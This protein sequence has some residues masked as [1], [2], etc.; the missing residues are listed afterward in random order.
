[1]TDAIGIE[2]VGTYVPRRRLSAEAVTEAWNRFDGA[3]IRQTSVPGPD[4]DSLTMAAEAARRALDE[5][6]VEPS[7][8]EALVFATTTP[9]LEESDLSVRLGE[10]LGVDEDATHTL[11][12]GSTNAGV[13]ALTTALADDDGPTLVV[14]SD[15]PRGKPDSALDHAA[16]AGAAAFVLVPDGPAAIVDRADY[17]SDYP[18]TRFREPGS[19]TVD[20]LDITPYDRSAYTETI[21]GAVENLDVDPSS[22]DVVVLQAPNGGLP[23]RGAKAIGVPSDVVESHAIVHDLGDLGAASVPLSLANALVDGADRVLAVGYGSG[24]TATALSVEQSGP[25]TGEVDLEGEESISYTAYLRLRGEIT[26]GEPAGGGA[27]VSVPS[28]KRSSPQR[29]RLEA[30]RCPACD[31]LN[32][33][34]RGACRRC[35]ELVEY[36]PAQLEP[37]GTIEAVSVISQ[38]GAP[39]E[40]AELQARAGDYATA[41]VAFDGTDGGVASA[42]LLVVGTDPNSVAVGDRVEATVRRIYTQEGVT[43][44]GLKVRPVD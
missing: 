29:Y 34:P 18:G 3:G 41:I 42:P 43:R 13:R 44:Y 27:Y 21:R 7:D 4:E 5:S 31:A 2:A 12:T 23:Y 17:A 10:F 11:L 30:G 39:P 36:E 8:L 32:F 19:T 6:D 37:C 15:A 33:L 28:W 14:A 9:P 25:V 35:H 22:M 38:G 24:A 26:N 1:M 20:S 16:G 40:F